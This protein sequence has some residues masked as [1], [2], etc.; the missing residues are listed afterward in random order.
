MTAQRYRIAAWSC[1]ALYLIAFVIVHRSSTFRQPAANMMY[2][3]Y[4]DNPVIERIEF[5]GFWPLRQIGYHMP[6]F[7][8][9][10]NLERKRPQ[11]QTNQSSMVQHFACDVWS[12]KLQ[13]NGTPGGTQRT[14]RG[15]ARQRG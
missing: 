2:W 7:K 3:Y 1:F 5:Y 11:G 15:F 6:G 12:G 14:L 4:S 13:V 10:H 9:R 8:S